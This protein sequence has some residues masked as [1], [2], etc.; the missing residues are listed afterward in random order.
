VAPRVVYHRFTQAP[1]QRP[2]GDVGRLRSVTAWQKDAYAPPVA[3][4]NQRR[5]LA[6]RPIRQAEQHRL[7][8]GEDAPVEDVCAKICRERSSVDDHRHRGWEYRH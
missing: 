2:Y 7:Q 6:P 4:G 1:Q 8:R 3:L 5:T